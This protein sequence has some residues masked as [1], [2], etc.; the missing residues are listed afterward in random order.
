MNKS[1]SYGPEMGG[2]TLD[3]TANGS[4]TD[5][6]ARWVSSCAQ[7]AMIANLRTRHAMSWE[8]LNSVLRRCPVRISPVPFSPARFGE[9]KKKTR[10]R[11]DGSW[12]S[13]NESIVLG[14]GRLGITGCAER[15]CIQIIVDAAPEASCLGSDS[16]DGS[17]HAHEN[18][19]E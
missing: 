3:L 14:R 11:N 13:P 4:T 12:G 15:G 8:V 10:H 7:S 5:F 2:R 17:D 1:S 9:S 18:Q 16:S 19:G 6:V